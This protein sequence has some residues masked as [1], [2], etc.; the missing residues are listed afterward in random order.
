MRT[1]RKR[2][3]QVEGEVEV[4]VD[5]EDERRARE[6]RQS[7]DESFGKARDPALGFIDV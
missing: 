2:S 5:E 1:R 4:K 3:K 6:V 7:R